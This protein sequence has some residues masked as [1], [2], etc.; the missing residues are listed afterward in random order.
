MEG[1]LTGAVRRWRIASRDAGKRLDVFIRGRCPELSRTAAARLIRTGAILV[2]RQAAKPGRLLRVNE[3]VEYQAPPPATVSTPAQNL[4]L[5]I[6]Y[7]DGDLAV[8][9]KPAGLVT[10][11]APGHPAGTLVNALLHH[12]RDLSGVGGE[13]RPGIVHRLDKDTSGLM[14]VAK[15]DRAHRALADLIH[16]RSVKRAYDAVVWGRPPA[17]RQEIETRMGRDPRNRKRFAVLASR[18]RLA[19]TTVQVQRTFREFSLLRVQLQTGRTHQIRV[20]C[21]HL[22]IPVVGDRMYGAAGEAGRLAKLHLVRPPRQL[23]HAVRLALRHP[24]TGRVLS[25][26]APWPRDFRAFVDS[27]ERRETRTP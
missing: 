9:N 20:H 13:L 24:F 10:H 16:E 5:E 18:G 15:H 6:L 7:E 22:G 14:L 27:L 23:L 12:L 17:A 21:R 4:P 25:W 3:E 2:A 26:E 11:P 19:S 1:K 8:I